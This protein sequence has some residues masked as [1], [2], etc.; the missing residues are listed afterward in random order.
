MQF[1][2]ERSVQGWWKRRAVERE[3]GA[4][5]SAGEGHPRTVAEVEVAAGERR[6]LRARGF[7]A[8]VAAA[9]GER[10]GLL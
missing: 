1:R 6:W 2:S 4:Y 7:V 3:E 9:W 5:Q 10:V 8:R